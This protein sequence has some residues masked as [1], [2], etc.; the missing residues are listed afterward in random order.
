MCVCACVCACAWFICIDVIRA[1][2]QVPIN[3]L[4]VL[5]KR[6]DKTPFWRRFYASLPQGDVIKCKKCGAIGHNQKHAKQVQAKCCTEVH[7]EW[8]W[9]RQRNL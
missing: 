2:Q 3:D 7:R 6:C 4:T 5:I 1:A 9:V 8:A